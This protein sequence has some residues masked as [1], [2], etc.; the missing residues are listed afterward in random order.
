MSSHAMVH[1]SSCPMQEDNKSL[2][3]AENQAFIRISTIGASLL[4]IPFLHVSQMA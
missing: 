4:K 2:S 1:F 3:L